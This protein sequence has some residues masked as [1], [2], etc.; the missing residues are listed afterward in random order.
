M[1]L[2]WA[3]YIMHRMMC[4]SSTFQAQHSRH[5]MFLESKFSHTLSTMPRRGVGCCQALHF[6]FVQSLHTGSQNLSRTIPKLKPHRCWQILDQDHP[7]SISLGRARGGV[8]SNFND[9]GGGFIAH[10]G[11]THSAEGPCSL[12]NPT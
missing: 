12:E 11:C 2:F 3:Q 7:G 10:S 5:K 8:F 1:E 4:L 9:S 6:R